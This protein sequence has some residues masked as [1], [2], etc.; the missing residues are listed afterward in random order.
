MLN[1]E[2]VTKTIIPLKK[3]LCDLVFA[4]VKLPDG[5]TANPGGIQH[6]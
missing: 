2:I 3:A 6:G 4:V 5:L 1:K